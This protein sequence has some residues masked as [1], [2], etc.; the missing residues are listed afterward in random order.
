MFRGMEG[1]FLGQSCN[2]RIPF[3]ASVF[4]ICIFG[5]LNLCLDEDTV[6]MPILQSSPS[7]FSVVR[8]SN[9]SKTSP[10]PVFLQV[11]LCFCI[12]GN[13]LFNFYLLNSRS[14]TVAGTW[15]PKLPEC[16]LESIQLTLDPKRYSQ[17]RVI[18]KI[19]RVSSLS[20][21]RNDYSLLSRSVNLIMNIF[22]GYFCLLDFSISNTARARAT[23]PVAPKLGAVPPENW[24]QR[25]V[26]PKLG[27][28][29]E[30]CARTVL[31]TLASWGLT[32]AGSEPILESNRDL[33]C[34]RTSPV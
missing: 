29:G 18:H 17:Q 32:R 25:Q 19:E 14:N 28:S 12:A 6:S 31:V 33:R 8:S 3:T 2:H 27:A 1:P 13:V 20:H 30:I 15:L 26:S 5:F 9:S 11:E 24:A 10:L 21:R 4:C 23:L 22:H 16:D 7:F 34:R